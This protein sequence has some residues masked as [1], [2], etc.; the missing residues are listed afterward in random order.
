MSNSPPKQKS[1]DT[2]TQPPTMSSSATSSSSAAREAKLAAAKRKHLKYQQQRSSSTGGVLGT[3]RRSSGGSVLSTTLSTTTQHLHDKSS[4]MLM[5]R[6]TIPSSTTPSLLGQGGEQD[7]VQLDHPHS[8]DRWRD[9]STSHPKASSSSFNLPPMG[10]LSLVHGNGGDAPTVH[11]SLVQLNPFPASP[12]SH[13]SPSI[14]SSPPLE[15]SL[16]LRV[17]VYSCSIHSLVTPLNSRLVDA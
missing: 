13:L 1:Q 10:D 7:T 16:L 15:V 14:L 4:S 3:G 5:A 6:G 8:P 17:L 12:R 11:S 9:R 2:T